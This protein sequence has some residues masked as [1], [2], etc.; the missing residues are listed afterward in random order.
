MLFQDY[1]HW[2]VENVSVNNPMSKH[3][4]AALIKLSCFFLIHKSRKKK[5]PRESKRELKDGYGD[6][7]KYIFIFYNNI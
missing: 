2:K 1:S 4:E 3:M 5:G 6:E 7:V